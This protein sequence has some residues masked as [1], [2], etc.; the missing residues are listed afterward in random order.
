[1]QAAI[2]A[3]TNVLLGVIAVLGLAVAVAA[4]IVQAASWTGAATLWGV[5]V[6]AVVA[7]IVLLLPTGRALRTSLLRG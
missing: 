6:A 4:A 2:S 5:L 7:T 3:Q 1:V